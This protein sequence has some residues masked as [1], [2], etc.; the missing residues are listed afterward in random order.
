QLGSAGVGNIGDVCT[1]LAGAREVPDEERI[2]V[3]KKKITCFCG[4][5]GA[6]DMLENPADFQTT[7][8]R[9]KW[10]ARFAAESVLPA[11]FCELSNII[12]DSCVLPY[13][14]ICHGLAGFAIPHDGGF[15]LISDSDRGQVPR[16]EAR[17]RHRLRDYCACVL[18]DLLR[19]VLDPAGLRVDLF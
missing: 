11:R 15:P 4:G 18:P 14:G 12:C 6:F 19:I 17:F 10:Q 3:A 7:E 13:Q 16:P 1:T 9:R 5:P 2:N 8:I